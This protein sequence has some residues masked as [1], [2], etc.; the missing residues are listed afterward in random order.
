MRDVLVATVG[1]SVLTNFQQLTQAS[2]FED[3]LETQPTD[4]RAFLTRHRA[5]I[6]EAAHDL[7]KKRWE[8]A[9]VVLGCLSG[10]PRLFGAE[11]SSVEALLREPPYEH[12]KEVLLLHSDTEQGA[13]AAKFLQAFLRLRFNFQTKARRVADLRDDQPGVF[14]TLGLRRLVLE[15]ARAVREYG[16]SR[17]VIDAT[18]GYKAQVAVAVA[19]GQ[20]FQIPVVYRFE[21]FPEV[22]EIPPLPMSLDW[23]F[24]QAHRNLLELAVIPSSALEEAFGPPLTE[25]NAAFSRFAVALSGPDAH[26]NY[27][28]SPSGQLLL[29]AL[30]SRKAKS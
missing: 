28:L 16:A 9:A 19:L 4:E 8:Q 1:T 22:I 20:V 18:G 24:L 3:W 11:V 2:S 7:T 30:K 14:R 6:L 10:T 21:R 5:A 12:I 23:E 15:L 13:A 27:T 29:E 26:G 17:I 25:A